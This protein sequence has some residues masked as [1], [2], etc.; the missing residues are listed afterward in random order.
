M[1]TSSPR[2]EDK[3][4]SE[5]EESVEAKGC[6]VCGLPIPIERLEAVPVTKKCIKCQEKAES[7]L[8]YQ[9]RLFA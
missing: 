2:Q 7:G 1:A 8:K 9:S 5:A 4:H 6:S 3:P